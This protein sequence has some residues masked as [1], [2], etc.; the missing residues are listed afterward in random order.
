MKKIW[1]SLLALLAV[2]KTHA[3][4]FE[5][6]QLLLDWQ[7]L[8]EERQILTDLKDGYEILYKGYHAIRDVCRGSFDL[9]KAFLDGLL[10]VSPSVRAYSRV[11]DII[12]LAERQNSL[13]NQTWPG[14]RQSKWLRA[15]E[16]D[17]LGR[18]YSRLLAEA[19]GILKTLTQV[20][21]NDAWRASDAERLAAID[22]LYDEAKRR[23]S[24]Q[25]QLTNQAS[26]LIAA[27]NN[28]QAELGGLQGLFQ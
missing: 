25:V 1:I 18:Q 15:W 16:L 24:G 17:L 20:L 7:K 27:R 3:Q 9:H 23:Y 21:T 10:T 14:F 12:S 8:T 19:T 2:E 28:A 22:Q 5:A 26:M 13:Y 6:Q 11:A 4:S